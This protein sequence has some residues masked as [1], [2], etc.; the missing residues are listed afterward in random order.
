MCIT[1]KAGSEVGEPW[2]ASPPVLASFQV[3]GVIIVIWA[4][5]TLDF[6]LARMFLPKPG[7]R[8]DFCGSFTLEISDTFREKQMYRGGVENKSAN[9]ISTG[10]GVADG[11][12]ELGLADL[13]SM[14]C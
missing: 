7:T 14:G 8:L 9:T 3:V 12:G 10:A 13:P 4:T 6:L 5:E 11:D 1:G 2:P